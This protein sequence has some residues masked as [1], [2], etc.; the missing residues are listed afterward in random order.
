[1]TDVRRSDRDF[2]SGSREGLREPQ[3]SGRTLFL[4]PRTHGRRAAAG[5]RSRALLVWPILAIA[6]M[7]PVL[8]VLVIMLVT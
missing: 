1:M 3:E 8:V 6:V 5:S 4:P 2:D 7:L